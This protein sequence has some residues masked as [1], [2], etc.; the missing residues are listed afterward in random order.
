MPPIA[1]RMTPREFNAFAAEHVPLI[2]SMGLTV[3]TIGDGEVSVRAPYRAD[4]Q[5]PGGTVSGPVLM[6]AA[7]FAMY[8][9]VIS[10]I[11]MEA[12]AVT[13]NLNMNFL[14]RPAPADVIATARLLKLG[15]RLAVGEVNVR[16][17]EGDTLVAHATCTYS[18]P[19]RR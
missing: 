7:D 14:I 17:T 9:A 11:G 1:A 12:M 2:T 5:R 15:A 10:R 4:F 13:T 8:G 18:L 6:A 19:P 3:E 16:S